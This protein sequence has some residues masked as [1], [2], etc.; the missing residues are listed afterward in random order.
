MVAPRSVDANATTL[1]ELL[2]RVQQE[3]L[4][5]Q[6]VRNGRAVAELRP[7]PDAANGSRWR[8]AD[9]DPT[10]KPQITPDDAVSPLDDDDWPS[11][12]RP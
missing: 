11:T 1:D 12:E 3:H 6:I 5:L 8:L 9:I 10:L 2:A 4:P 7:I